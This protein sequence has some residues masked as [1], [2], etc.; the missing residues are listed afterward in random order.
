MLRLNA[1]DQVLH[2]A[3]NPVGSLT[4]GLAAHDIAP[5]GDLHMHPVRL[6]WQKR[7]WQV[8]ASDEAINDAIRRSARRAADYR[9]GDKKRTDTGTSTRAPGS[10]AKRGRR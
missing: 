2:G 10:K 7:A 5:N 1:G 9:A 6:P 4:I 3:S 8:P